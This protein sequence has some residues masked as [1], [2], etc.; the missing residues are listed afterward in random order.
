M[1]PFAALASYSD[2]RAAAAM[3]AVP[4]EHSERI[5]LTSAVGRVLAGPAMAVVDVPTADRAAMD[6]FALRAADAATAG[7]VLPCCGRLAAGQPADINVEPGT[8]VEIATGASVSH[9]GEDL[10][11]GRAIG[12]AGQIVHPAFLS[13][14]VAGGLQELEVWARPR[15]LVTPTGDEVVPVGTELQPGQVY[16]S[17]AAGLQALLGR[18]GAEVERADIVVDRRDA[19]AEVLQR[20]GFDL[21]ITIGGTSVGRRDLVADVVEDLGQILVHGV[22]VR[23]G[24]PLLVGRVGGHTVIGLPGFPT[25]CM[26]QAHALV[27]PLVRRI[28]RQP[29]E[30]HARA[31]ELAEQV[32]SPA[33]MTHLMP[34]LVE[35]HIATPSFTFSS[36]V[37]SMAQAS[38][39]IEIDPDVTDVAAGSRVDVLLF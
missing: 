30:P 18:A 35:G 5:V 19:L 29:M 8:C 9:R 3:L 20:P 6:G 25:T 26:M 1:R 32:R 15:V 36:A 24:K 13:A 21:V 7:A 38:G 37:S 12:N 27:D 17:N 22:A 31:C 10:L 4:I 23:P 16:D 28:A 11:A 14:C 33:G 39:W 34:V 2:V